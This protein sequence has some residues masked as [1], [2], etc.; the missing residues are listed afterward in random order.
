MIIKHFIT[1][2]WKFFTELKKEGKKQVTKKSDEGAFLGER[3]DDKMNMREQ[4]HGN[5]LFLKIQCKKRIQ[6]YLHTLFLKVLNGIYIY[7]LIWFL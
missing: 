6:A 1:S 4:R 5:F 2:K 3:Q 7:Y